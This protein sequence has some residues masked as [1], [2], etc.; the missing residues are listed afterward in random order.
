LRRPIETTVL[1]SSSL[2]VVMVDRGLRIRRHTAAS[3]KVLKILPSDMGRPI[4]DIRWDVDVSDLDGLIAGVIET[5]APKELEV[6]AKDGHWYSLQIRPYR[7]TDDKIDGAVIVLSDINDAKQA[8][9]RIEKAKLFTEEA[10]ATVR[11]PLL[12]L[13]Q[14]LSVIYANPSFMRSFH[15]PVEETVG[16]FLQELGDGQWNIPKLRAMLEGVLS[17]DLPVVD[18]EVEHD[19]PNLGPKTMLLNARKIENGHNNEPTMLL[20]IEDITDRKRAEDD[21]YLSKREL[22]S[23]SIRLVVSAEDEKRQ[24]AREL[25]DAFG[26][27][28]ALL[29]LHLAEIAMLIPT[30]PDVANEKLVTVREQFGNMTREIQDF[31]R[32][33]HPAILH[34]MGLAVALR[35]ECKRCAEQSGMVVNLSPQNIP[36]DL[37][38]EIGLC[39][40][41]VTQEALQNIW[42]HA[43]SKKVDVTV[44]ASDEA[45][46]LRVEDFGKGFD[47]ESVKGRVGL[48]LISMHERVRLVGGSLFFKSQAAC[49]TVVEALIP[50]KKDT[51]EFTA[52]SAGG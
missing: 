35:L 43:E 32:L 27:K 48:G 15:V 2:P 1:T 10:L 20:A 41:R 51:D 34:E 22:E 38:E 18:F 11:E 3:A 5:L 4:S 40:Y 9:E 6:Q 33:L 7:T 16:K 50:L 52:T 37:P 47:V 31:A 25:H 36:K 21:L 28:L 17:K 26:Q 24:L 30:R 13:Q 8:S 39:L 14:N 49:G 44:K 23:L 42:K 45:I 46:E 19:F 12:V 29:N